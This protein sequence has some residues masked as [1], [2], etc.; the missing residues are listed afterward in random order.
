M[1]VKFKWIV[2]LTRHFWRYWKEAGRKKTDD[3]LPHFHRKPN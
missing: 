1:T 2:K 3:S